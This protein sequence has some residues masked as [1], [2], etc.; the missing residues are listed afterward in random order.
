MIKPKKA[1][2]ESDAEKQ[3]REA[4]QVM[5]VHEL[6]QFPLVFKGGTALR[7]L[8]GSRRF[9]E[10]LDFD[11]ALDMSDEERRVLMEQIRQ[12]L[13]D[14]EGRWTRDKKINGS[15][16]TFNYYFRAH[17]KIGS[18]RPKSVKIEVSRFKSKKTFNG[19]PYIIKPIQTLPR[20]EHMI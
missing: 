4:A 2:N 16:Q 18:N 14:K 6:Q 11:L 17:Y 9:S 13:Y 7:L 10:D 1:S 15:D 20:Y 5:L 8:H 19:Y 3:Y 12:H